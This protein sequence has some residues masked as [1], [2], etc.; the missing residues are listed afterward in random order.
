MGRVLVLCDGCDDYYQLDPQTGEGECPVCNVDGQ[1]NHAV[2]FND[3]VLEHFH[4]DVVY[5]E[6]I[7]ECFCVLLIAL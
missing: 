4:E 6:I 2:E 3:G 1:D 5:S 7:P